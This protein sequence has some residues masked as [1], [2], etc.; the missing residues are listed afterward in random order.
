M[1]A[2]LWQGVCRRCAGPPGLG[3]V[4]AA[5]DAWPRACAPSLAGPFS[6]GGR[7]GRG[8]G[9]AY[10]RR[11]AGCE[12]DGLGGRERERGDEAGRGR[13]TAGRGRDW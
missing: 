11:W 4:S 1:H 9:G 6:G 5:L 7:K 10:G 2:C 13:G 12:G 3:C 8:K